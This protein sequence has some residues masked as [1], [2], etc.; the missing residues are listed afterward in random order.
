MANILV[1]DD[2]VANLKL[3]TATLTDVGFEVRPLLDPQK[4]VEAALLDKPNLVLLDIAMPHIDGYMVCRSFK[5]HP[6][7]AIFPSF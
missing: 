5:S 6:A 2:T 4:A 1:I 7:C 3:M